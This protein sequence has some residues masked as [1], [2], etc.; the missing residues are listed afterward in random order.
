MNLNQMTLSKKFRTPLT[1]TLMLLE[2]LYIKTNSTALR[3]TIMVLI[4]EM[5]LL[6]CLVNDLLD[7]KFFENNSFVAK[8]E[9]FL[10]KSAFIFIKTMFASQAALQNSKIE[11]SMPPNDQL[12]EVLV[13]D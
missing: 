7:L 11:L 12:P 8:Q 2:D 13:G 5:N 3:Q 1:S 4:S 6:I 9:E 10:V